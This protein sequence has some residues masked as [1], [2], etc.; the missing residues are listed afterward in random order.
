MKISVIEHRGDGAI[1]Y[2]GS[3]E[4]PKTATAVELWWKGRFERSETGAPNFDLAG[5]IEIEQPKVKKWKWSFI[6][7]GIKC[8]TRHMSQAEFD[9]W[10]KK[11]S[12]DP[13]CMFH[14]DE[15]RIIDDSAIEEEEVTR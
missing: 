10:W 6:S 3:Y 15:I 8:E 5:R 14:A 2:L 13:L 7:Y 1:R 12:D 4:V 9:K 11:T